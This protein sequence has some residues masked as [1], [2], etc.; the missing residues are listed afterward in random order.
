MTSVFFIDANRLT[1]KAP[2]C[3]VM[4]IDASGLMEFFKEVTHWAY[5]ITSWIE[6]NPVTVG[7]IGSALVVIGGIVAWFIGLFKAKPKPAPNDADVR[8]LF[9]RSVTAQ[10]EKQATQLSDANT[11]ELKQQIIDELRRQLAEPET[12]LQQAL[13]RNE[14]LESKLNQVSAQFDK[15]RIIAARDAIALFDYK[16]AEKLFLSLPT[17]KKSQMN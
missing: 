4:A 9:V 10:I 14:E 5:P 1:H 2:D 13:E 12:S 3:L 8:K 7:V 16:S 6:E 17:T 15:M 11:R